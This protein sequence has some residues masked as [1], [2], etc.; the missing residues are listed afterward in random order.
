MGYVK[1]ESDGIDPYG[2]C[3]QETAGLVF[4][5]LGDERDEEDDEDDEDDEDIEPF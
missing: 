1:A 3:P 4:V 2:G 5:K